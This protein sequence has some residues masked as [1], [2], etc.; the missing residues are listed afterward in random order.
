MSRKNNNSLDE[1]IKKSL[2]SD[3]PDINIK[4]FYNELQHYINGNTID[5]NIYK[6]FVKKPENP[7]HLSGFKSKHTIEILFFTI[8]IICQQYVTIHLNSPSGNT[9]QSPSQSP[10]N[11]QPKPYGKINIDKIF[12][13]T[14]KRKKIDIRSIIA[15]KHPF[16]NTFPSKEQLSK[17][18]F[19]KIVNNYITYIIEINNNKLYDDIILLYYC[20]IILNSTIHT[21]QNWMRVSSLKTHT[22][23]TDNSTTQSIFNDFIDSTLFITYVMRTFDIL[24]EQI[25]NE[26]IYTLSPYNIFNHYLIDV[27]QKDDN[28]KKELINNIGIMQICI[29][30]YS[31][32]YTPLQNE[33]LTHDLT[34]SNM[35]LITDA[36][37][38]IMESSSKNTLTFT[39]NTKLKL[40]METIQSYLLF[41]YDP[42]YIHKLYKQDQFGHK[43]PPSRPHAPTVPLIFK[44][45]DFFDTN[46]YTQLAQ[47]INRL[48]GLGINFDES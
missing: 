13:I 41:L 37:N 32:V 36:L 17:V 35:F 9:S 29:L 2:Q 38:N 48:Y 28:L 15:S 26:L 47:T 16:I 34:Q 43:R 23:G 46:D 39:N 45:N 12:N 8:Y 33:I 19:K 10:S 1:K 42:T 31:T 30:L 22:K 40:W 11:N 21:P 4:D 24:T 3:I 20:C 25:H 5:T 7:D 6:K 44:Y 27:I 14:G 18:N